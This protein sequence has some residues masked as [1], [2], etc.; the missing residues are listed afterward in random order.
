MTA[1]QALDW[2]KL[3][4]LVIDASHF[5][6]SLTIQQ[7]RA[8]G[9]GR[10][11]G[12]VDAE[13]GGLLL[14][15]VDPDV[16]FIEWA[17]S[18]ADA[19]DFVRRIRAGGEA[20]NPAVNIFVLSSKSAL[21][22]VEAARR[23]GADGFMRKPIPGVELRRRIRTVIGEPRPFI[24]TPSYAGP[25]RRR[26]ADPAYAGPWLRLDDVVS[27]VA[28]ED[29]ADPRIEVARG[30]VAAV[31]ARV[32][33]L[34]GGDPAAVRAIYQ[35]LRDLLGVA[36][37]IADQPLMLAAE[38]MIRYLQA[39]GAMAVL[40]AEVVRTHVQA[41]RQLAHLPRAL[42]TERHRVALSLRRMIDKKLRLLGP[43]A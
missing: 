20:P 30:Y 29:D 38:E 18:G 36:N 24:H 39:H 7:L 19:L 8:L 31:E 17:D 25:C 40:E 35:S 37:E 1:E 15:K 10:V 27:E 4:A 34:A 33:A 11:M 6:R 13:E 23:A 21:G 2:S 28:E 32:T 16:V 26:R 9:F 42:A 3:T 43:A 5:E 41:L 22:N 14:G 12:A